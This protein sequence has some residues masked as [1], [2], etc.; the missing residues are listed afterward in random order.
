METFNLAVTHLSLV[1]GTIGI[2]VILVGAL[3]A[4]LMFI[5][6][7]MLPLKDPKAAEYSSIRLVLGG[8]IILGL[9]FLV[10]K[11]IMDTMLLTPGHDIW[12][13]L[14]ILISVVTV[15]IVLTHFMLKEMRELAK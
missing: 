11:D 13:E 6:Q 1:V 7:G 9:D 15:R 14:A 8:H 3:R 4:A 12:K 10:A 5:K 2:V